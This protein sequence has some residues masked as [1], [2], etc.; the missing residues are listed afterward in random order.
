MLATKQLRMC[1][2]I[3]LS[4]PSLAIDSCLSLSKW[5]LLCKEHQQARISRNDLTSRAL[6]ST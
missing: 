4:C 3:Q 1:L 2:M 5:E 6:C